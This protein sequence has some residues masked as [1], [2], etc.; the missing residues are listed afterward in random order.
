MFCHPVTG[1]TDEEAKLDPTCASGRVLITGSR[2]VTTV[3][4]GAGGLLEGASSSLSK[5]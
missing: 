2:I 1:G 5:G 4:V 3:V